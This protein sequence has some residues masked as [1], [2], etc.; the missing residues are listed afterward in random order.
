MVST[1]RQDQTFEESSMKV[2]DL[3]EWI[4]DGDIG[5]VTG[6]FDDEHA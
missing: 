4:E 6:I 5:I 1:C 2:G 3:V